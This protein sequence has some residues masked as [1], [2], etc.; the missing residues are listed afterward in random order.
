MTLT[1]EQIKTVLAQLGIPEEKISKDLLEEIE[2][3]CKNVLDIMSYVEQNRKTTNNNSKTETIEGILIAASEDA[4]FDSFFDPLAKSFVSFKDYKYIK[5]LEDEGYYVLTDEYGN[6]LTDDEGNAKILTPIYKY[7][8]YLYAND[9]LFLI[10]SEKPLPVKPCY[11]NLSG[12]KYK[13]MF[14]V[15]DI[16]D[17]RQELSR[18]EWD[19]LNT[20]V[21]NNTMNT[22][23]KFNNECKN[24]ITI[25]IGNVSFSNAKAK[26]A[27]GILDLKTTFKIANFNAN[28]FKVALQKSAGIYI[29]ILNVRK[30]IDK[31]G[32]PK[33]GRTITH[34]VMIRKN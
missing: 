20:L 11:V 10:K 27:R 30:Y 22:Y 8:G 23:D 31:E 4:R 26:L 7:V 6:I 24:E 12:K 17:Q 29:G 25:F 3:N 33:W 18:L 28:A 16:L 14:I 32:N 5:Y 1:V 2:I 21:D 9:E 15:Q 13:T 19:V 34:P